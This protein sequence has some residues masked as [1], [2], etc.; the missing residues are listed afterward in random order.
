M[1]ETK[2]WEGE[3]TRRG[4]VAPRSHAFRSVMAAT[5]CSDARRPSSSCA[6]AHTAPGDG[7]APAGRPARRDRPRC[8]RAE[9]GEKERPRKTERKRRAATVTLLCTHAAFV[10]I[11]GDASPLGIPGPRAIIRATRLLPS[12]RDVYEYLRMRDFGRLSSIRY[13]HPLLE[14]VIRQNIVKVAE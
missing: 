4:S 10:R 12:A 8:P 9:R 5:G 6:H 1:Y 14:D 2:R 3:R 13:N 11:F 7:R